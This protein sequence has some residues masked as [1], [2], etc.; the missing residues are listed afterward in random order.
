MKTNTQPMPTNWLRVIDAYFADPKRV[1]WR[2]Y[3][4]AYEN[5]NQATSN[6]GA[7]KIWR[8]PR[9]IAELARREQG[10]RDDNK[11][12]AAE[13]LEHLASLVRAD[14]RDLVEYRRGACRFCHGEGHRYHRTQREYADALKAYRGTTSGSVAADPAGLGFDLA[15]GIGYTPKKPPHPD[16]PEC[17]GDGTGYTFAKDMRDVP[18]GAAQLYASIKETEHGMEIKTRSK[19]KALQMAMQS[20]GLLSEKEEDENSAIPPAATVIFQVEDAS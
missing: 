5:A 10:L 12:V 4:V 13:V 19:D 3:S 20:L 7:H 18:A 1:K 9:F 16:C 11:L 8:D 17:Y 6:Q 14:P 2:A 15:G